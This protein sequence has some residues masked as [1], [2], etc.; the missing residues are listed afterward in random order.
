MKL[1]ENNFWPENPT[2]S[3]FGQISCVLTSKVT[4]NS[5]KVVREIATLRFF[6]PMYT[7]LPS[8]NTNGNTKT[9]IHISQ[10][11]KLSSKHATMSLLGPMYAFLPSPP[12]LRLNCTKLNISIN[13]Y[14]LEQQVNIT[15]IGTKM[16][17]TTNYKADYNRSFPERIFLL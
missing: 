17:L 3:N 7:R 6:G 9:Q 15:D 16:P 11:K 4:I 5:K 10:F 1:T 2:V 8:P 12:P 13:I 14:S